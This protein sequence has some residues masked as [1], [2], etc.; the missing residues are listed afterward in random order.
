MSR[1]SPDMSIAAVAPHL[2][3]Q[4]RTVLLARLLD[5]AAPQGESKITARMT[6]ITRPPPNSAARN[7][8]PSRMRRTRPSSKTSWS[9]R[10]SKITALPK[11]RPFAEQ[12]S[13][14]RNRGIGA[15]GGTLRRTPSPNA[16][17]FGV[18]R[19]SRRRPPAW[20]RGSQPPPREEAERERPQH[21]PEHCERQVASAEPIWCG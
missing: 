2:Y 7:C 1:R 19:P 10:N 18:S 14:H 12:R 17:D 6:I 4:A 13:S 20:R 3:E 11:R 16:M 9:R 21:L 8:Q 5:D 15:R